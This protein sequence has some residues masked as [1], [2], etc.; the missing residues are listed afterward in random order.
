MTAQHGDGYSRCMNMAT[1]EIARQTQAL[2]QQAE[3][4]LSRRL[5]KALLTQTNLSLGKVA[6]HAGLTNLRA[7][8]RETQ[9]LCNAT[10]GQMRAAHLDPHDE[11]K[12]RRSGEAIAFELPVHGAY[13]LG[14]VFNYLAARALQGI[15][16]VTDHHYQRRVTPPGLP[17]VYVQVFA[18]NRT[19]HT[20]LPLSCGPAQSWLARVVRLFDLGVDSRAIDRALKKAPALRASVVAAPGLRVPGAWDGFESAVRAVLGQQVSVA[21]GTELANRMVDTYGDG[22]F[23]SPLQLMHQ[24]IAELGMPG[25]RGRAIATMSGWVA[26]QAL[27]LLEG[28]D[29]EAFVQQIASIKGIGP[30]TQNYMRLRIVKDADAFPHNDWVVLKQLQTTPA[31]ALKHAESWRPWRAYALMHIWRLAGLERERKKNRI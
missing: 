10:A 18:H 15:E 2:R 11:G 8:N 28:E 19:L 4:E 6:Y 25:N 14:W 20:R 23:P 22:D 3:D 13:D 24:E 7:L 29:T 5:I 26:E 12:E 30:W 16:T 31:Q 1:P 9:R 17:P 27:T 21:R